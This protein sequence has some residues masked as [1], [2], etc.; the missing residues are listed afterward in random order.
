MFKLIALINLLHDES[1]SNLIIRD[2]I[3][4]VI[5]KNIDTAK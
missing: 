3:V 5:P 1:I 4:P 2:I